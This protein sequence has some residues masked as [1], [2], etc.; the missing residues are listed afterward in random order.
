MDE[1]Q[2]IILED[3]TEINNDEPVIY[4]GPNIFALA[5]QKFQVFKGG[6]PPYVKRAIEK[7]PEIKSL[8]VP[9]SELEAM[10]ANIEKS[11]TLE[12]RIFYNVQKEAEKLRTK[13]KVKK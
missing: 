8:I 5:L 2:E 10:R 6:L 1:N 11:G 12:A 13:G 7:I 3:E 4:T 9:V